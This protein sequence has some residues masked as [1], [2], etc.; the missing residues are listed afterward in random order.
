MRSIVVSAAKADD[1]ARSDPVGLVC[2]L[3]DRAVTRI[4]AADGSRSRDPPEAGQQSIVRS[5][6][7]QHEAVM[8]TNRR[9]AWP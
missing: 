3:I 4:E 7:K 6:R 9:W 5:S 1:A 8:R 2:H